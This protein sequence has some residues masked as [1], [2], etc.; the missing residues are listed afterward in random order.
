MVTVQGHGRMPV[1]SMPFVGRW[2][3][4]Q[5]RRPWAE[6]KTGGASRAIWRDPSGATPLCRYAQDSTGEAATRRHRGGQGSRRPDLGQ[7]LRRY[8]PA[9]RVASWHTSAIDR[10]KALG[11]N[12]RQPLFCTLNGDPLDAS[13]CAPCDA[14]CRGERA[15]KSAS[16]P[17]S[18]ATRTPPS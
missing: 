12:G 16:T 1:A 10:R 6:G 2:Q 9:S 4:I 7:E 8:H 14:A 18:S 13:L 15:S 5:I 11:V 3:R 17:T